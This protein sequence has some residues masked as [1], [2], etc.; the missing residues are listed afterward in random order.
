MPIFMLEWSNNQ[1]QGLQAKISRLFW[2]LNMAFVIVNSDPDEMPPWVASHLDL[3]GH[4]CTIDKLMGIYGLINR[5]N[6]K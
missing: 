5:E 1:Y 3:H 2:Q 6:S 4:T